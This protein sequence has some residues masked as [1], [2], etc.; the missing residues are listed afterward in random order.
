MTLE[1]AIST[2]S[3]KTPAV[4]T[5]NVTTNIP[6]LLFDNTYCLEEIDARYAQSLSGSL[7]LSRC[8]RLRRVYLEG[9]SIAI[10]SFKNGQ[11]V[12]TLH[13]PSETS[14]ILLRNMLFLTDLQLPTNLSKITTF[15]SEN[16]ISIDAIYYLYQIFSS[17]NSLIQ[18]FRIVNDDGIVRN[19]SNEECE[20]LNLIAQGK[21]KDGNN[22]SYGSVS[23]NGSVISTSNPYVSETVNL[24]WVYKQTLDSMNLSNIR[25]YDANSKIGLYQFFGNLRIIFNPTY[26]FIKFIDPEV[27]RIVSNWVG[28]GDGYTTLEQVQG[29]TTISL[30]TFRN[31]TLI[32]SFD[33]FEMFSG[34]TTLPDGAS[35]VTPGCFGGCSNLRSIKLPENLTT[36]GNYTFCNCTNLEYVKFPSTLTSLGVY[37]I[38]FNDSL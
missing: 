19:I 18:Y 3:I 32:T 5:P 1:G 21:D 16:N 15:L 22:K 38:A 17:E 9:T 27:R 31:N 35:S 8:S 34:I 36:V 28:S 6:G 37:Y 23:P 29:A 26:V 14:A 10:V 2:E 7:D 33:E 13:Y 24:T 4:T 12:E 30:T 25:N 11:K 20:M